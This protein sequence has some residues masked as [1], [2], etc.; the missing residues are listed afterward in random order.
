MEYKFTA[1]NFQKEVVESKIPV[2][3]DFY[4]DWCGPCQM[5]GPVVANFA[6]AYDGKIKIGKVNSDEEPQLA[7]QFQVMSIPNFVFIKDGK[8]VDQ[9]IGAMPPAA[10]K[11]KLDALL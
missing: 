6:E 2:M 3:I 10:L 11:E 5:M 1:A 7:Q 8:V 4:A 9:A